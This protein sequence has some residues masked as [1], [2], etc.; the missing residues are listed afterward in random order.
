ARGAQDADAKR[1][2]HAGACLYRGLRSAATRARA[3]ARARFRLPSF[4]RA[5]AQARARDLR[6]QS[7][8][9]EW[10]CTA[11]SARYGRT[12]M[13]KPRPDPPPFIRPAIRP[14]DGS[15]PGEQPQ[16]GGF[17]KL[18]TNETPYP[19]SPRVRE[20]IERCATDDVRLYPD[21]LAN[22]LRDAAAARYD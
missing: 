5:R 3:C 11:G 15:T 16:A 2:S 14:M 22:A 21:P 20:V 6:L 17:I 8:G 10:I 1:R 7:R 13:A 18:N 9:N 19:P 12:P 4:F